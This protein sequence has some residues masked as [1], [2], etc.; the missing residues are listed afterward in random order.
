MKS[1]RASDRERMKDEL[2]AI[3][4]RLVWKYHYTVQESR[5]KLH[6]LIDVTV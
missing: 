6:E 3:A 5:R 1:I 2:V 4:E